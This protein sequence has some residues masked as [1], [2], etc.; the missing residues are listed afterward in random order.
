MRSALG[1]PRPSTLCVPDRCNDLLG[2]TTPTY[3]SLVL[4]I[5]VD[6]ADAQTAS[7]N[8]P[9][10]CVPSTTRNGPYLSNPSNRTGG[11]T[12]ELS[13]FPVGNNIWPSI[14]ARPTIL[15]EPREASF[16]ILDPLRIVWIDA[17]GCEARRKDGLR[18]PGYIEEFK[19]ARIAPGIHSCDRDQKALEP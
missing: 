10:W 7:E 2:D 1:R 6:N 13:R 4:G 17:G 9:I 14:Y 5:R 18:S 15:F 12:H 8:T 16:D 3:P 19:V 11:N